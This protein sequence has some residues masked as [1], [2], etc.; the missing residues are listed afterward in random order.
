MK[1]YVFGTRGFPLVQGGVEKHC[2]ILY[3]SIV[4]E[5]QK[6]DRTEVVVYRRK[7]YISLS[8]NAR[9]PN[10]R[11]IDL[12]STRIKGFEVLY[13]SLLS[14]LHILTQ[15]RGIIHIHNI[16]PALFT[17][18]LRLFKRKVILTYHSANYE[19]QKW[20]FIE[21]KLLK[22]CEKIALRYANGIIFVNRFHLEKFPVRIRKKS[23][24]IP[25]GIQTPIFS[26][27]SEYLEKWG[28]CGTKYILSVGR[29]TPEKGFEILIKAFLSIHSDFKLAIAGGTESETGY[30]EQLIG[31]CDK[32]KIVFTG[33]VF[34]EALSQL[35]THAE[36]FVLPSF[37]EGFPLVLLEAMSYGLPLIVSDIPA[38]RLIELAPKCYFPVGDIDAL[39]EKLIDFMQAN[40]EQKPVAYDL[41]PYDWRKIAKQT[42]GVYSIKNF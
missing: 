4:S 29:I 38:T 20:N 41:S 26:C 11:F 35:Y 14:V 2:E 24:Y 28:L 30:Y 19:H 18:V 25:N 15:P 10:I 6:E 31:M 40:H 3:P 32:N 21:R 12:P 27:S 17:P 7:P 34:G 42:I 36:L 1:I 37:S 5:A 22:L 13:H 23:H 16:G 8:K 39:K 33:Y 9:Y